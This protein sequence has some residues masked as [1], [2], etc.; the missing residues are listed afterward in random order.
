MLSAYPAEQITQVVALVTEFT[1][2]VEQ[3]VEHAVNK[4]ENWLLIA[5]IDDSWAFHWKS[6]H[7]SLINVSKTF[8]LY[9]LMTRYRQT[10][11]IQQEQDANE[12]HER[13]NFYRFKLTF[14]EN[15]P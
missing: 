9:L 10:M 7:N 5:M 4:H 3:P 15:R 8:K 6:P 2:Q 11:N 1:V 12:L 13:L 14:V